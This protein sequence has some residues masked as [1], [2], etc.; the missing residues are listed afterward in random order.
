MFGDRGAKI[1]RSDKRRERRRLEVSAIDPPRLRPLRIESPRTIDCRCDSPVRHTV[2]KTPS[3][4]NL[5]TCVVALN[6]DV[7]LPT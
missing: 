7:E 6:A 5:W 4:P 1:H 3:P 2:P